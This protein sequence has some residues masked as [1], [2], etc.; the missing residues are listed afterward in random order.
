MKVRELIRVFLAGLVLASMF[1]AAPGLADDTEIYRAE[2]DASNTG[3]P[4]VLIVFDDSGSMSTMVDQQRPP[5]D[6]EEDDYDN[7]FG[8]GRIYWSTDGTTPAVGSNNWFDASVNRC[9]SSFDI[10]E[11][12]GNFTADRARRWVDSTVIAGDCVDSCP[13]GTS[14]RNNG[15]NGRACYSRECTQF[16]WW[17]GCARRAWVYQAPVTRECTG[18]TVQ[19]GTWQ[20]LNANVKSP[21]HLECRNDESEGITANGSG[22]PGG[23]P[24]NNVATGSEYGPS[25]DLDMDWGNQAYTFYTSHYLD[26]FHDD[27]LVEP[28]TRLAIAQDV[29]SG[30]VRTNPGIDFGLLE[31]NGNRSTSYNGGRVTR[32]I[33]ENMTS[34]DRENL[35]DIV[36]AT[37]HSGS[38]P[39]CESFYE[40]YR[41]LAGEEV[42]WGNSKAPENTSNR[43]YYYGQWWYD[44]PQPKDSLAE[45]G[46]DYISPASDCAYTYVII[47]TDGEPQ[48]DTSA[49]SR[50]ETLTGKTCSE[51]ATSGQGMTKNC[52]PE[53]AEY[54][55][56][57]DLDND[58]T[59]GNQFGITYTIG[60]ATDQVLLSDT[61]DKGKGQ[62]YTANSAQEL[63]E[64][65]Q[66]ALVSILSTDTTFTSPAVAVDTFTRTQSRDDIFYA[67]F[68]PGEQVDWPG[69][70]KKLKLEIDDGEAVLV[71]ANGAPAIDPA[72]GF[73]KDS[74][75]T[76]WGSSQ[77]GGRV[78]QGGA[79]GLLA[80]RD[81]A[82]RNVYSDTGTGG[83]LE[84]LNSTNVDADAFGLASES[85]LFD[86]FGVANQTALNRQI[87]WALGY[88]AYDQDGDGITNEPRRW[89]LGDI[90]HSQPQVLNYG[91]RSGFS[92]DEPDMR[93]VVGTNAG[94]VHMFRSDT[95]QESWAFFPKELAPIML[96]RRQNG[97]SA[98]NVYGMDLTAAIYTVDLNKDGTIDSG[99][100]DKAYV[101]MGMRRGGNSLYALDVSNPDSPAFLWSIGPG[102]SGFGELGQSWSKPVVTRIPGYKDGEGVP[103]PVLIFGAG[104]DLGKDATGIATPDVMG[105][106]IFIVD[107]TTG[108]LVWSVTPA[109]N[110][111]K[112]MEE[113]GLQHAVP[114]EVTVLDSNGDELTDRIYFADAGGNVWRV[115]MPGNTLP[116]SSQTAWQI[117]KLAALSESTVAT[118]RRFFNAPDVVRIRFD[119]EP[120]D[121]VLIGSGDRT[122]PNSTDV[123]DRFYMI[124][125]ERVAPYA[126]T[127]PTAA[128]CADM[129]TITDFRCFLPLDNSDLF[130]ITANT[131]NTG[132]EAQ[133]ATALA[134]LRAA[135]GWRIDLQN[136]G[137]K[138]LAKSLT[139]N[140]KTY[141]TTFT[142]S[143]LLDDINVCEPQSGNGR[144][145]IVDL[146][147]GRRGIIP[148]G[149][150][151]PDTPSVHFG[152]DGQVRLL[153]PPG[154]PAGDSDGDGDNDCVGGVC[155][156]GEIFRPPYGTYWFQEEY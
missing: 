8:S 61:A 78:D 28:R 64:A 3:R 34:S 13:E 24:Q 20:A 50:I 99:D 87:N 111:A 89:V 46:G 1:T 23:F 36:N 114:A 41:Y 54:M 39:L 71:D 88:D 52:L 121:A 96:L 83:A 10:L 74:A 42:L 112:N 84:A 37:E 9:A 32:R 53:L 92:Q 44:D 125:D 119:G 4:K 108:E 79:G 85:E 27:S 67:M 25:V 18:D 140:G 134:A 129:E 63:T 40:A 94:F 57:T 55:A 115:D 101:Y 142:P 76:F 131:L 7:Q 68:K 56:N 113:S 21:R 151:I 95:G 138:S 51:Y 49:T 141:F 66:G 69:N 116:T 107:A 156:I 123:D 153:L 80:A 35:I 146:V 65:F 152:E 73:I 81:P 33:I 17:G 103:K 11:S 6:P 155:D 104:Y 2:F 148:L 59:N 122:N 117:N 139:L 154:T 5:Y 105:R 86:L 144:L 124:R 132:T 130:D 147:D 60:F 128:E 82:T 110:S 97:L 43:T 48:N 30:I 70:I 109:S 26:W 75:V 38:T 77:D 12:E 120:V 91:A 143:S 45:S 58:T 90:L 127:R 150:I 137:E 31:M 72:T 118:D 149:P 22:I 93:L 16:Y 98:D 136:S 29:I 102:D 14:L 145:Y 106:G 135:N 15:S 62:Y 133:Q 19:V 126:D 100:G 47:M